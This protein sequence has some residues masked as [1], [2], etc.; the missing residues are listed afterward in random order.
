MINAL[1]FREILRQHLPR[2]AATHK[3]EDGVE[4]FTH[5]QLAR[6]PAGF[7]FRDESFKMIVFTISQVA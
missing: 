6:P 4:D 5:V 3:V 2:D 7:R 1:P